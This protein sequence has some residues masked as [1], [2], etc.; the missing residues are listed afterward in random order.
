VL[1]AQAALVGLDR[2]WRITAAP[3][4]AL[5]VAGVV[6]LWWTTGTN[7]WAIAAIAPYGAS[8]TDLAV[9][10]AVGALLTAG[11]A[12]RR[13]VAVSS[14]LAYGPGLAMAGT[15]L[16]ASQLE[17]GSDWATLG[18]LAVG[19]VAVGVGGVRRLAAPLVIGSIM[20]IGTLAVSAGPRLATAPT[21][22]WIAGGGVALLIVAALVERSERPLLPVG[23]RNDDAVSLVEQFC[24]EFQ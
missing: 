13:K 20:L 11:G 10:V 4:V 19:T 24:E 15:W 12:I 2:R 9:G 1:G 6:S 14:W 5:A 7:A 3:G 18:A 17:A 8:G 23:R 16:I 21:W 22:S